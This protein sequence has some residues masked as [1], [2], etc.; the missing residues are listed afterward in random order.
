MKTR[1][2]YIC[3]Q[4]EPDGEHNFITTFHRTLAISSALFKAAQHTASFTTILQNGCFI[5]TNHIDAPVSLAL[6]TF[7][8]AAS[9]STYNL[10][11]CLEAAL[12]AGVSVYDI[13]VD[14]LTDDFSSIAIHKQNHNVAILQP[15]ISQYWTKL[16][17]GP[18]TDRVLFNTQGVI[19]VEVDQWLTKYDNCYSLAAAAMILNS[20]ALDPSLFK[21]NCYDGPN[22][23]IFLLRNGLL[24]L[25]CPVTSH[26]VTDRNLALTVM[27]TDLTRLLLVLITILLP[28]AIELRSLKGQHLPYQST[29]L[30]VLPRRHTTGDIPWR[31]NS[32][33][34]NTQLISL[35]AKLFGVSLDG[36]TICKM[37]YQ[38]LS[39][40]FPLLLS[41]SMHLRSPVDDL[42]QHLWTTG[43][44]NYG[45]LSHFPSHMALT[46][47]TS[48]PA[49]HV[50]YCEIWHALT[51]TGLINVGWKTM[52]QDTALFSDQVF[53]EDA[54]HMA[55]RSI[56][57]HYQILHTSQPAKRAEQI[58][59]LLT[60]RPFL[61]GITVCAQYFYPCCS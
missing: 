38:V 42:A 49:R 24:S 23:N 45:K 11:C 37:V 22:R 46:G 48:R 30:W 15:F 31:Y 50:V 6:E 43:I 39:A 44:H 47:D 59:K 51:H 27:P 25:A 52:V 5:L 17:V 19:R 60:E 56:L 13:P 3:P 10:K 57:N 26:R 58:E 34:V 7:C 32:A 40:K 54:F 29:H 18:S 4:G 8:E 1:L 35:T 36:N 33:D 53:S 12:P 14:N 61:Q 41:N 21:Y 2:K 20:G 55:R 9:L 16:L 28:I